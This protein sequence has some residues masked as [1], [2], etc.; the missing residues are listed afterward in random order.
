MEAVDHLSPRHLHQVHDAECGAVEGIEVALEVVEAGSQ[1]RDLAARG[2]T[3]PLQVLDLD[4]GLG[5]LALRHGRR[6]GGRGEGGLQVGDVR[7]E[8]VDLR[9]GGLAFLGLREV[10]HQV[11][12]VPGRSHV[13]VRRG[14]RGRRSGP[15]VG[16]WPRTRVGEGEPPRHIRHT[17]GG[18][19]PKRRV[20]AAAARA[21][22]AKA[23]VIGHDDEG[24]ER[25]KDS[26]Y[27]RECTEER[28]RERGFRAQARH[29]AYG[30]GPRAQCS[31]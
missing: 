7:A 3:I 31:S 11:A 22:N 24:S 18:P 20:A 15:R 1:H 16:G 13:G 9:R 14:R 26:C 10:P 2:G 25:R 27:E 8:H 28:G 30:V 4:P 6:L 23:L 17:R 5:G 12:N 19:S 29:Y 21:P